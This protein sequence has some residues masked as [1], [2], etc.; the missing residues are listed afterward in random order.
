MPV[1]KDALGRY[2]VI[3]EKL[4][5]R[6]YPSKTELI[7]T[8]LKRLG[9]EI[10]SRTLDE[11][12]NNMRYNDDLAYYAPIAFDKTRKGY[13]Y[14]KADYSITSIPVSSEDLEKLK[15][16]ANML[17]QFSG[18][19][20]LAE[21]HRPIEQLERII[22]VGTATGKWL[23]QKVIQ[24]E[25]PTEWPDIGI[26]E[27]SVEGILQKRVMRVRYK[28]FG[29]EESEPFRIHPYL[30]KEFKNRW[31]LVAFAEHRNEVRNYG[32]DRFTEAQLTTETY[33]ETFDAE[34]YFSHSMGI[35]V[36]NNTEPMEV[37]LLFAPESAAYVLTSGLHATQEILDNHPKKGLHMRITVHL[38]EELNMFIRSYGSRVQ[39][40]KPESLRRSWLEDLRKSLEQAGPCHPSTGSG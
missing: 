24:L 10:G 35:T 12:L 19:P 37:E 14:E 32:L 4:R 9:Y 21:I 33:N 18:V 3:D 13:F 34:S 11:D 16:A 2:R 28:P 27:R 1:N 38:S 15:Y 5:M 31:Y 22:R 6:G 36:V 20:Y 40:L 29:S 26:F 17:S 30:L 23:N 7:E 8:I 25:V 39:V